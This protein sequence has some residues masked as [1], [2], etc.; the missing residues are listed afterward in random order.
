MVKIITIKISQAEEF[1]I[2]VV[3]KQFDVYFHIMQIRA[4]DMQYPKEKVIFA[5][6]PAVN[7]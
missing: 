4:V 6:N 1:I 3:R 5:K 7:P 2:I